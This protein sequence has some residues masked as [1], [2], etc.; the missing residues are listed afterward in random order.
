[1]A[2]KLFGDVNTTMPIVKYLE[3][4]NSNKWCK[5]AIRSHKNKSLNDYIK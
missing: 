5:E 3:Y 1:M 4:E 2:G